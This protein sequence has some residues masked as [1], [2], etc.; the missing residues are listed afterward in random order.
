MA[1]ARQFFDAQKAT[2]IGPSF[3]PAQMA[4]IQGLVSPQPLFIPTSP[5]TPSFNDAWADVQRAPSLPQN[6]F[7]SVAWTSEFSSAALASGPVV[8][9]TINSANGAFTP[10]LDK[11]YNI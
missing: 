1:M 3:Q 5:A 4:Q 10:N 9:Q 7:S 8:Q 11:E 2:T 6:T